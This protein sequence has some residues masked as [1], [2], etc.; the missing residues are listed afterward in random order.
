MLFEHASMLHKN[1][2]KRYLVLSA[3]G[4]RGRDPSGPRAFC[5]LGGAARSPL[6]SSSFLLPRSL[7]DKMVVAS[8]CGI[9]KSHA[10]RCAW[11]AAHYWGP[12]GQVGP[13]GRGE[14]TGNLTA[15]RPGP[16]NG[17]ARSTISVEVR[18]YVCRSTAPTHEADSCALGTHQPKPRPC[19]RG[20]WPQC[21]GSLG[22]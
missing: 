14:L 9:G 10:S 13:R 7:K 15:P 17:Q 12:L 8:S 18:G 21:G 2:L 1:P 4:P 3:T 22:D 5:P 19:A 6:F 11:R 16:R 20:G